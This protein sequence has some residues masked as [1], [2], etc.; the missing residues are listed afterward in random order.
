MTV[1][2]AFRT[3][4]LTLATAVF[5]VS[6]S[7]ISKPVS[8]ESISPV[9]F[10]T[11]LSEADQYIGDTVIIGGY[12]LETKN[13]KEESTLLVLQSPLG[14]RQEP[15]T[16]DHTEGRFIVVHKEFLEPE[17]YSKDRKI[18]VAGV[19]AGMVKV[20]IDG[21]SYPHLKIRSREIFLWPEKQRPFYGSY[22]DPWN[23]LH[24]DCW[25]WHRRHPYF[26]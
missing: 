5:L 8:N 18:T 4:V 21:F 11:L 24:V 19:V 3:L 2:K 16:K 12:I 10:K 14:H 6:C 13:S 9:H 1:F 22:Y 25:H 15:K 26:W 23:C 7:V 17:I 20:K